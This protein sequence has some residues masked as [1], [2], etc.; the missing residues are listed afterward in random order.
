PVSLA[1][2]TRIIT[3]NAGNL[4]VDGSISNTTAIGL[5]KNGAGQLT[6]GG[7]S[8]YIG[9]TIVSNGKLLV[10]GSLA[11]ASAVTGMSGATLGGRGT[12]GNVTVSNGGILSPGGANIGAFTVSNL[13]LQSSAHLNYDLGAPLT[14]DV[15]IATGL[16]TLNSL[17]TNNFTFTTQ[18]GFGA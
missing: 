3:V 16:L 9:A 17:Q 14:S 11:L 8:S 2:A 7:N 5:T 6:L 13:T 18:A 1:G 10:N 12:V 4:S 15:V